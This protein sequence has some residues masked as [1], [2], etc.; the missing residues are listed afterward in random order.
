MIVFGLAGLP[1]G[2][3]RPADVDKLLRISSTPDGPLIVLL[4]VGRG[5]AAELGIDGKDC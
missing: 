2:V 5:G 4:V 1:A 3:L